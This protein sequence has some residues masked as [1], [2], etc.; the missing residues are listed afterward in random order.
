VDRGSLNSSNPI[1]ATIENEPVLKHK[2]IFNILKD[3]FKILDKKQR[4]SSSNNNF[5]PWYRDF[6]IT[7]FGEVGCIKNTYGYNYQNLYM[8]LY[9]FDLVYENLIADY[10]EKSKKD[11]SEV[12]GEM[13]KENLSDDKKREML[14]EVATWIRRTTRMYECNFSRNTKIFSKVY[15]GK[16]TVNPNID[17]S[18]LTIFF[19]D[20]KPVELITKGSLEDLSSYS[21]EICKYLKIWLCDQWL[22]THQ[23]MTYDNALLQEEC[24]E[25]RNYMKNKEIED[26]KKQAKMF[27]KIDSISTLCYTILAWDLCEGITAEK[28]TQ[29]AAVEVIKK[30]CQNKTSKSFPTDGVKRQ[31]GVIGSRIEKKHYSQVKTKQDAV[32]QQQQFKADSEF[33]PY[34]LFTCQRPCENA[35]NR[36]F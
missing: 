33:F 22:A 9:H 34:P 5:Q 1:S 21:D 28:I 2:V 25:Y 20:N 3:V 19:R 6:L 24:D 12:E 11:G 29:D 16:L 35:T 17:D 8:C 31:L 23:S 18:S 30:K 32:L 10:S 15:L 26:I 14:Q 27:T 4:L 7:L 13:E 36:A